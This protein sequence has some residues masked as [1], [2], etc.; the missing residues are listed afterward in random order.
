MTD[1][2]A[3]SPNRRRLALIT[4]T[5]LFTATLATAGVA[6]WRTS[7]GDERGL[8]ASEAFVR[9]LGIDCPTSGTFDL[10][11]DLIPLTVAT[12]VDLP[13][14]V[15]TVT[16]GDTAIVATRDGR[17]ISWSNA[18]DGPE[19]LLDLSDRTSVDSDRGLLGLEL[20]ADLSTLLVL[21]S[22]ENGDTV[23]TGHRLTGTDEAANLSI[24]PESEVELLV[25]EQPDPRHNGGGMAIGPEGDLF[26]GVGDG[27]GQGDPNDE[28][29]DPK[30]RLGAI[31]RV[32]LADDGRAIAPVG[33]G[34]DGRDAMVWATGVRNPFRMWFDS[35]N[36]LW[37]AD[38]G[39]RCI[40]E[41]SVLDPAVPGQDLGWSALEGSRVFD[42]GRGPRRAAVGPVVEWS[43]RDGSCA[44]IG[45]A[46]YR[47]DIVELTGAQ[48]VADLCTGTVLAILD[49][50]AGQLPVRLDSPVDVNIGPDGELWITDMAVGVRRITRSPL[51]TP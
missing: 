15:S 14:A 12:V 23:L 13:G 37:V 42:A 3:R 27:G 31:L 11:A 45:G 32:D 44:A 22:D 46:E 9:S 7:V 10:V 50:Q 33:D 48:I 25:V 6:A 36:R 24:D 17:I 39:E 20:S 34:E 49:G 21:R 16:S 8:G 18:A 35:A 51:R 5:I 43:H 47:G 4:A 19:E 29:S 1:R 26:I 28:A 41:V 30:S 40:E 2:R 38:V